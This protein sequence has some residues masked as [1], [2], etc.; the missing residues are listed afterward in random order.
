MPKPTRASPNSDLDGVRE[1]RVES[2]DAALA[3][4]Q[5]AADLERARRQSAGRPNEARKRS[6][7]DR[8]DH[9]SEP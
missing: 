9:R 2:K 6:R 5:D 3:A 8:S 1:D 4:G 7:D